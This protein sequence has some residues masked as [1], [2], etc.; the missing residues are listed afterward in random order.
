M[1]RIVSVL[2]V[3]CLLLGLCS[4]GAPIEVKKF[5]SETEMQDYLQGVWVDD[6]SGE[7]IFFD[8]GIAFRW[9]ALSDRL[10]HFENTFDSLIR[11]QGY[12]AFSEINVSDHI[13]KLEKDWLPT[14]VGVTCQFKPNKGELSIG[15]ADYKIYVGDGILHDGSSGGEF[16]KL[17][18]TPSYTCDELITHF[19]EALKNYVPKAKDV[20][21]SNKQYAEVL[22]EL[23]P[24]IKNFPLAIEENGFYLYS[25]TGKG[26]NDYNDA[27][28]WSDTLVSLTMRSKSTDK[29]KVT[30]LESG[31]VIDAQSESWETMIA[32]ALAL[33]GGVPGLPTPQELVAE[34]R[35]KGENYILNPNLFEYS[36]E[37]GGIKFSMSE[38]LN[39]NAKTLILRFE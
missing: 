7:L 13:G 28:M 12:K 20:K 17:S 37:I 32:D 4:C 21:L 34:F 33:F 8:N 23:H 10:T 16:E 30:L 5:A 2:V 14:D 26:N 15:K 9:E 11:E 25:D 27:L 19:E 24:E 3:V 38:S 18:D 29:Y 1:K 6:W 35:E 39:N 31:L 22:M 36:T